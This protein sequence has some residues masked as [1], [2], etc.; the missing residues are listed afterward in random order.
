MHMNK[1][2]KFVT[3]CTNCKA[4][5][6]KCDREQP[7]SSCRKSRCQ[8]NCKYEEDANNNLPIYVLSALK[9]LEIGNIRKNRSRPLANDHGST[10]GA[11]QGKKRISMAFLVAN[12]AVLGDKQPSLE[13]HIKRPGEEKQQERIY[14]PEIING[15]QACQSIHVI[16]SDDSYPCTSDMISEQDVRY[17]EKNNL[18]EIPKENDNFQCYTSFMTLNPYESEDDTILGGMVEKSPVGCKDEIWNFFHSIDPTLQHTYH[19]LDNSTGGSHKC[20]N[21]LSTDN[22]EKEYIKKFF[23]S[24]CQD[25]HHFNCNFSN[26]DEIKL[27]NTILSIAPLYDQ[28]WILINRYFEVVYPHVPYIDKDFFTY[29]ISKSLKRHENKLQLVLYDTS[30]LAYLGILLVLLCFARLSYFSNSLPVDTSNDCSSF[31]I[32]DFQDMRHTIDENITPLCFDLITYLDHQNQDSFSNLLLTFYLKIY[33]EYWPTYLQDYDKISRQFNKILVGKAMGLRLHQMLREESQFASSTIKKR[34][35]ISLVISASRDLSDYALQLPAKTED[36][37]V[38]IDDAKFF[39]DASSHIREGIV[40]NVKLSFL[41]SNIVKDANG[42]TN[43]KVSGIC[44]SLTQCEKLLHD[45]ANIENLRSCGAYDDPSSLS[46]LRQSSVKALLEFGCLALPVFWMLSLYYQ[47]RNLN[48][49]YF[50]FKKALL[51]FHHVFP[52]I[53]ELLNHSQSLCDFIINPSLINLAYKSC[54]LCLCLLLQVNALELQKISNRPKR[55]QNPDISMSLLLKVKDQ[56]RHAIHKL[57]SAILSLRES[58]PN[59]RVYQTII[60]ELLSKVESNIDIY[61]GMLQNISFPKDSYSIVE[62]HLG[63]VSDIILS[64][65]RG[66]DKP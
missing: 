27:E 7:C 34:L 23:D 59:V 38:Q 66:L 52:Y 49:S 33:Y 19:S 61:S 36:F 57:T 53:I 39:D 56:L 8:E 9:P 1:H 26:F 65:F 4:R 6:K 44:K 55:G 16:E 63:E 31:I 14:T 64:C 22:E 15:N 13:R 40:I 2:K 37:E 17:L 54:Q 48:M 30:D 50:Y 12:E 46:F 21:V 51:L 11:I 18:L 62:S 42:P 10:D 20:S 45:M 25:T 28:I 43:T 47:A 60:F 3:V 41:L 5:K 24:S 58:Y 35:W 32:A 29:Q